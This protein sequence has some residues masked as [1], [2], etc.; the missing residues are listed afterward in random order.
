VVS[1]AF[2]GFFAFLLILNISFGAS[3]VTQL[4]T[5]VQTR[6]LPIRRVRKAL[7]VANRLFAE[8]EAV[9]GQV[10][11]AAPVE[12]SVQ[13]LPPEMPAPRTS[14]PPPLPGEKP[15]SRGIW[16]RVAAFTF[17]LLSGAIA[18]WAGLQHAAPL[19]YSACAALLVNLPIGIVALV[20]QRRYRLPSGPGGI[21]WISVVAHSVVLPTAYF[22]FSFIYSVDMTKR[23][24]PAPLAMQLPLSAL[25]GLPGFDTALWI[26]GVFCALLAVIGC[27]AMLAT[28]GRTE[29]AKAG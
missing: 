20:Q 3:C 5:R 15:A 10:A 2:A 29:P 19:R 25:G 8:I 22:V 24:A 23:P 26:Y 28:R 18:L 12:T 11:V 21:V 4:Q 13:P 6:A 7:R 9:Q 16:L 27:F 17:L 1:G 14:G